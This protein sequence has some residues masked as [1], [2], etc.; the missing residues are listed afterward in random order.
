MCEF[1]VFSVKFISFLT[2]LIS[3]DD[4]ASHS[5]LVIQ[6]LVQQIFIKCLPFAGLWA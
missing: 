4:S 3:A 6:S 1:S 2:F 5:V